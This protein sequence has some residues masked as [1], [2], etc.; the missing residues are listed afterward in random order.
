MNFDQIIDGIPAEKEDV[1]FAYLQGLAD[2]AKT[3]GT[4]NEKK[5]EEK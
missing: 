4:S 5:E 2:G 1:A 3:S